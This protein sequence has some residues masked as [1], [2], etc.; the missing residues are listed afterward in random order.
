[1]KHAEV[2][3]RFWHKAYSLTGLKVHNEPR[4]QWVDATLSLI[5]GVLL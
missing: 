4:I 3:I 2:S 5:K 1:M